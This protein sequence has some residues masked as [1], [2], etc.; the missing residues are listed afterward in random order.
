MLINT[1]K[2]YKFLRRTYL[3]MEKILLIHFQTDFLFVVHTIES[4]KRTTAFLIAQI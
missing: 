2:K 1:H 4:K 3:G